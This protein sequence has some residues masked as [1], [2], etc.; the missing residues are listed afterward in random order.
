MEVLQLERKA[1]TALTQV[2]GDTGEGITSKT[3]PADT[4]EK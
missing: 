1:W 4:G 3:I 2:P